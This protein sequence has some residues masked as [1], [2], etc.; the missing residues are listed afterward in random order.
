MR[1]NDVCWCGSGLKF[2]R[3]HKPTTDRVVAG[4]GSP[5]R[6]V[7]DTIER[8]TTPSRVA[9]TTATKRWSRPPS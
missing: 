1:P 8:L 2:K 5:V 9:P 3:C 6:T 7:P 4:T